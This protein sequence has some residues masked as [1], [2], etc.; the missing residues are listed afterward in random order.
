MF[1]IR[2]SHVI[3]T[4]KKLT[5]WY[6]AIPQVDCHAATNGLEIGGLKTHL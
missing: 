6:D 3:E 1:E 5:C 2:L 4:V